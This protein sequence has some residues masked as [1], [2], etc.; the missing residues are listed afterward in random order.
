MNFCKFSI[1]LPF[2]NSLPHL[3]AAQQ[4]FLLILA[5]SVYLGKN[6]LQLWKLQYP[7]SAIY[8]L[9]PS[10]SKYT[11]PRAL[12]LNDEKSYVWWNALEKWHSSSLLRCVLYSFIEK[13]ANQVTAYWSIRGSKCLSRNILHGIR[14]QR[15]A[16]CKP[17]PLSSDFRHS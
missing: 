16:K 13:A 11:L 6:I 5:T 10:I 14:C 8:Q 15:H 2:P 12:L 1:K 17:Y 7:A 3:K 4:R 9:A